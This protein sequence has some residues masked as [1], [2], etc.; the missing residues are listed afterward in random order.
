MIG[1]VGRVRV[2]CGSLSVDV[3]IYPYKYKYKTKQKYTHLKHRQQGDEDGEDAVEV[4]AQKRDDVHG[5]VEPGKGG[6]DLF[7]RE[8]GAHPAALFRGWFGVVYKVKRGIILYVLECGI[9]VRGVMMYLLYMQA[10]ALG[11]PK[12]IERKNICFL[13]LCLYTYACDAG[14]E[15]EGQKVVGLCVVCVVYFLELVGWLID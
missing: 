9:G 15:A 13:K 4:V 8:A 12:N 3:H 5:A 2:V 6:R 11:P 10:D 1:S 14:L 7:P